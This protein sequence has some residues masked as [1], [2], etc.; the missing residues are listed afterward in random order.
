MNEPVEDES[1]YEL[2][3]IAQAYA[4]ND[5]PSSSGKKTYTPKAMPPRPRSADFLEYE[6]KRQYRRYKNHDQPNTF[7]EP[8]LPS[9]PKSSLDIN[10]SMDNY[11]YSEASYAAKMRQSAL[12]LQ[13]RKIISTGRDDTR[14]KTLRYEN[15]R[16][17][18]TNEFNSYMLNNGSLTLP[19]KLGRESSNESWQYASML[20]KA[21]ANLMKGSGELLRKCSLY[22]KCRKSKRLR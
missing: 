13:N 11:Y 7:N 5:F 20:R 9:R 6:S 14:L 10:S 4:N 2:D 12:Y 16:K 8:S 22:I 18:L 21:E 19:R 15:E 1:N 17:R 3:A